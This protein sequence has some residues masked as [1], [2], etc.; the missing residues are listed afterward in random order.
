MRNID[1]KVVNDFGREWSQFD[2]SV[3]APAELQKLFEDY[4]RVFPWEGLPESPMGFDL[5]CG[6]GRW[7]KIVSPRVSQLHCI[8]PSEEALEVAKRNLSGVTNC[9]FHL[10]GVDNI[11]LPN[12]SMDFGYSLGVLHHVPD[13]TEGIRNCVSKLKP[14]GPFLLYLYYAFDNRP[15]W[16]KAIWKVSDLIRRVVA[17]TPYPIKLATSQIIAVSIYYPLAKAARFMESLGMRVDHLPL[18]SYRDKSFYTMRTDALD[19]FGTRLERRFT[20][21]QI[22]EMMIE[23]G[24][25]KIRFS[26]EAPYWVA[27]GYKR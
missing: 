17:K 9:C 10:A 25:T 22:E 18:S 13:T 12:N 14:A 1:T 24:L 16:F 11:P 5:G 6:S 20:R 3:V 15:L 8:D 2:Q 4:F 26:E 7:A 27:V 21:E 19:R 23:A